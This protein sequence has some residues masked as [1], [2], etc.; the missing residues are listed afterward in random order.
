M[1]GAVDATATLA[2]PYALALGERLRRVRQQQDLSLHEV[3]ARSGGA[4]KASVLGAY[5]RGERAVSIT[6]LHAM[7]QFFRVPVAEL[8]PDPRGE[9]RAPSASDFTEESVMID[10][11]V[12]DQHREAEHL[13]ARYT[14]SIRSRRGDYNGQVLTVRAADVETL[15]AVMDTSAA[16]LR[17]RLSDVGIVR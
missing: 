10:L 12:L 13:L 9:R 3:E 1:S 17:S 11:V 2:D 4:L 16:A 14:D 7:A 15:A 6:R 5:E 8:L